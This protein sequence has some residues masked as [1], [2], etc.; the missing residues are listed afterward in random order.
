MYIVSQNSQV[1]GNVWSHPRKGPNVVKMT[2][3]KFEAVPLA[4]VH[5]HRKM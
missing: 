1:F 4:L 5:V 3:E 2:V